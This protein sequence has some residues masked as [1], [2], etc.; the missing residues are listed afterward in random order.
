MEKTLDR[1]TLGKRVKE[2]RLKSGYSAAKLGKLTG[3]SKSHINNIE[4][5]NC[6]ASAEVLVRI[7]N[8]LDTSIDVLL[9]ESLN[10]KAS[11]QARMY[12]F[13]KMLE[14]CSD[15]ETKIIVETV[16][17]LKKNLKEAETVTAGDSK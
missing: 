2:Y 12:E 8:V 14:D 7:A 16:K 4:S 5:A 11:Q 15:L 9:C 6:N 17:V 1:T 3:V 13:A 10:G